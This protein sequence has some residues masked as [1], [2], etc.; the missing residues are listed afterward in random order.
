MNRSLRLP[1]HKCQPYLDLNDKL[2]R[3]RN[4]VYRTS[5]GEGL[6][7]VSKFCGFRRRQHEVPVICRKRPCSFLAGTTSFFVSG[8]KVCCPDGL[9][10]GAA[11]ETLKAENKRKPP[12]KR[13]MVGQCLRLVW[14]SGI[15]VTLVM[16]YLHLTSSESEIPW[17]AQLGKC[18][19]W[20]LFLGLLFWPLTSF[21]GS[22]KREITAEVTALVSIEAGQPVLQLRLNLTLR[23]DLQI[24]R[25]PARYGSGG[26]GETGRGQSN[27]TAG[28]RY[29][30]SAGYTR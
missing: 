17:V 30:T 10:A 3:C 26:T 19:V 18:F 14:Y 6:E 28:K 24:S 9:S 2:R 23:N 5:P 4:R 16:E 21:P 13:T 8:I 1:L 7:R 15:S 25:S 20:G 22:R 11:R 27:C 29:V 12:V